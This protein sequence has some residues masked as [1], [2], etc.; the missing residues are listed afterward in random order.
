MNARHVAFWPV[1]P[2]A[3]MQQF[4][5]FGRRSGSVRRTLE[6]TRLTQQRHRLANQLVDIIAC[7]AVTMLRIDLS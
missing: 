7:C 3:V 5:R 4:G 1:T 2:L 6:A